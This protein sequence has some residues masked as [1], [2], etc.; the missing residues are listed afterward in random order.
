MDV[1]TNLVEE[2]FKFMFLGMGIVFL[3]LI[4]LMFALKIQYRVIKFFSLDTIVDEDNEIKK[5]SS[6]KS[7]QKSKIAAI[8]G[9]ITQ[10]N[11]R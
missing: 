9:A 7:N 2:A 10:F 1:Q 3:F 4:V 6:K 11:K 8:V 5:S